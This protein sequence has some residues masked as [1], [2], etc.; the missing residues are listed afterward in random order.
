MPCPSLCLDSV[1]S[2]LSILFCPSVCLV[3]CLY[4]LS[5]CCLFTT[6]QLL[7]QSV[8]SVVRLDKGFRHSEDVLDWPSDR[9]VFKM[10]KPLFRNWHDVQTLFSESDKAGNIYK[11]A[12][13]VDPC[14]L[15]FFWILSFLTG[16]FLCAG[17]RS[18]WKYTDRV[19][20]RWASVPVRLYLTCA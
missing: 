20:I 9:Y 3:S 13:H 1:L 4:V 11:Q 8:L 16:V 6:C 19:T 2:S 10:S 5:V 7:C 12:T 17:D 15:F 14:I 18:G